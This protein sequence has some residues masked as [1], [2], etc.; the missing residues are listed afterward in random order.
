[1]TTTN[2]TPNPGA[3]T[4]TGIASVIP[5]TY[6]MPN[7]AGLLVLGQGGP[8]VAAFAARVISLSAAVLVD[9]VVWPAGVYVL[10]DG[11]AEEFLKTAVAVEVA[12][13]PAQYVPGQGWRLGK[14]KIP[15]ERVALRTIILATATLINGITWPA[16]TY[17]TR[18]ELTAE[19]LLQNGATEPVGPVL[20]HVPL[21][22]WKLQ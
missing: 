16:A 11:W 14:Q 1:M 9:G 3:A 2:L 15:S 12:P 5:V 13:P 17:V 19:E 7:P 20:A 6:L 21:V 8:P 4:I 22:G 18:D 10:D